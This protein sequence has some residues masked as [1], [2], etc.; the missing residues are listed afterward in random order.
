MKCSICNRLLPDL[1]R[2][3]C[4]SCNTKIRRYRNKLR[5]ILHLG[6]KC[7]DCGWQGPPYGFDIHHEDQNQ[8]EFQLSN[9]ANK[10]WLSIVDELDKCK[11]LCVP[12]HRKIHCDYD[13][14]FWIEALNYQGGDGD[15][16]TEEVKAKFVADM[17]RW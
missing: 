10:S 6:G 17:D 11:L 3:R 16:L 15:W 2:K 7:N 1:R 8:K 14:D 9:V 13:R 4:N 5:C 12:C